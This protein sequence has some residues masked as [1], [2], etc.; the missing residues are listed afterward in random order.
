MRQ[1]FV[2]LDGVLADTATYYQ[3]LF[4][5]PLTWTD[6][7][8]AN[9]KSYPDFYRYQY[10]MPNLLRLWKGIQL[11]HPDPI[12]L[13]GIPYSIP[14][15]AKHKRQWVTDYLGIDVKVICCPARNKHKHGK[16]G[17]IL[18]DDRLKYSQF[19]LDMG[20]VFIH[21]T[22]NFDTLRALNNRF[23]GVQV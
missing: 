20:G 14:D 12:I 17:D 22:S 9:I 23:T 8:F 7:D 19:W 16:S 4:S 21:H 10:P 13:T 1:I 5:T 2:D 3:R 11:F 15:V 18:I 6:A